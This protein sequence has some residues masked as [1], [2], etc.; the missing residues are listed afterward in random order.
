MYDKDF[1]D[2]LEKWTKNQSGHSVIDTPEAWVEAA[3]AMVPTDIGLR[4]RHNKRVSDGPKSVKVGQHDLDVRPPMEAYSR[5]LKE[6][7]D[8]HLDRETLFQA[9]PM[10]KIMKMCL[11]RWV[12]PF[13]KAIKG[14]PHA[15]GQESLELDGYLH[16]IMCTMIGDPGKAIDLGTLMKHYSSVDAMLYDPPTPAVQRSLR[17]ELD[18]DTA[19]FKPVE[20]DVYWLMREIRTWVTANISIWQA[21][22]YHV[23]GQAATDPAK[24]DKGDKDSKKGGKGK[25]KRGGKSGDTS[26]AAAVQVS[27]GNLPTWN[28]AKESSL[29]ALQSTTRKQ[30][31]APS[32]SIGHEGATKRAAQKQAWTSVKSM[33]AVT[34]DDGKTLTAAEVQE[35]IS[36][37]SNGAFFDASI[38]KAMNIALYNATSGICHQCGSR[39]ATSWTEAMKSDKDGKPLCFC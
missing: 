35:V 2:K 21:K 34:C 29:K 30:K 11:D 33:G 8:V 9:V 5:I 31:P 27:A 26:A 18:L 13:S 7:T 17:S 15:N 16:G 32:D 14:M 25:K 12:K 38:M 39:T 23:V 24:S 28:D 3:N 19:E 37:H 36:D 10:P 4:E 20:F 1:H 6:A 22:G